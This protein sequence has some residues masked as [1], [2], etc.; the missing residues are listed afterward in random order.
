M[1]LVPD[2]TQCAEQYGTSP[3][4]HQLFTVLQERPIKA[5]NLLGAGDTSKYMNLAAIADSMDHLA[6]MI[7]VS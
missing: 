2:S 6:D 7:Q 1:P 3:V 5:E 4:L